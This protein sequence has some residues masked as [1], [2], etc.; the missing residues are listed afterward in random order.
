MRDDEWSYSTTRSGL[1]GVTAS[2]SMGF[3]R[4]DRTLGQVGCPR[5]QLCRSQMHTLSLPKVGQELEMHY[6]DGE[7]DSQQ[8]FDQ[9]DANVDRIVRGICRG[10]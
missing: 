8:T 10:C 3:N 6:L 9:E 4:G 2:T 5:K 1:L 7:S